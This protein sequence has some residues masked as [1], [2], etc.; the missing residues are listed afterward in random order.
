MLSILKQSWRTKQVYGLGALC[1]Y[2][3]LSSNMSPRDE[4]EIA[5]KRRKIVK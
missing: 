5:W 3:K 1:I 4:E 2:D